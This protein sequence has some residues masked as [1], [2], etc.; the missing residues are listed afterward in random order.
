[1]IEVRRRAAGDHRSVRGGRRRPRAAVDLA[2]HGTPRG[3]GSAIFAA[4]VGG[5]SGGGLAA[6]LFTGGAIGV[7]DQGDGT[8][9]LCS[10]GLREGNRYNTSTTDYLYL[11][12]YHHQWYGETCGA[13][14]SGEPYNS[15]QLWF[16]HIAKW[17]TPILGLPGA[18]DLRALGAVFCV[19]VAV[20]TAVAALLL[21]GTGLARFLGAGA[22]WL[23][24]ADGAFAGYFVSAYSEPAALIG[25]LALLLSVLVYWR[26]RTVRWWAVLLV[27]AG[28]AL[29]ITAKT[30]SASLLAT[31]IPL[32]LARPTFGESIQAHLDKGGLY[33][34][35]TARRRVEA[36]LVTRWPALI[37]GAVLVIITQ[38]YLAHQPKRFEVQNRYAAVFIEM[39]PHSSNPAA[40]LRALGLPASMVSSSGVSINAPGSAASTP[41]FVGFV[42]KTSPLRTSEV[43][44][45]DPARLVGMAGR[46]LKGMA[47]LRADYV[48]SYP[49]SA[50]RPPNT[51]ECRVCVLQTVWKAVFGAAPDL[52]VLVGLMC[53]GVCLYLAATRREREIAAVG[54]VGMFL[55]LS[56]IAQFW[57][58]ML[59]EG[60]SDLIKHM[61]LANYLLALMFVITGYAGYL[62]RRSNSSRRDPPAPAESSPGR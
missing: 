24:I 17:L 20:I 32:L 31:V 38:Q 49:Q 47:V 44:L 8:R 5:L 37:A 42:D 56:A 13:T 12:W 40:D 23:V 39:L 22:L 48:Y 18:L 7:S 6:R 35:V 53:F 28:A 60:A 54:V 26:T 58:V 36:F 11:T 4:V 16:L 9:L 55:G 10:L 61:V 57:V 25:I 21:P 34:R 50:Q 1:M 2:L 51:E 19:L 30:Q 52:I 14:G 27:C 41:Q 45:R 46:G 29:T 15:S 62:I 43:Y 59:T 33:A 3:R